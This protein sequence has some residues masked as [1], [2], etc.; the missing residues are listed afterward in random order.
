[1]AP[2]LYGSGV[3]EQQGT[4]TSASSS[5]SKAKK[6]LPHHSQH[7]QKLFSG[8]GG[9]SAAALH[10]H[11]ASAT[12]AGGLCIESFSLQQ[13]QQPRK[14]PA[15]PL[16]SHELLPTIGSNAAGAAAAEAG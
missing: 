8:V 6:M 11:P 13:Q 5:S 14:V 9:G 1:M 15:L 10:D 16:A 7:K 4:G 12:A 3:V 2:L